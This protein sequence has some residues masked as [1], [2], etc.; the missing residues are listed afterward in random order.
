M[1][2][3]YWL[4]ALACALALIFKAPL[5]H[6]AAMI[7]A[8]LLFIGGG[9]PHGAFDIAVLRRAIDLDRR[10][11]WRV[12]ASYVAVAVLMALL[13]FSVP[14]VALILFLAVAAVHFGEDWTML[15]EPL[16]RFAAGAAIIA[17]PT[18]GH[19]ND[20]AALFVAM[21]DARALILAR[22]ITAAAPVTLLV[23][24]VSIG[25]AWLDGSRQ[26]A[27]AMALCLVL[28]LLLPPVLGFAL[29]F[30]FLH[31]P[32]HLIA[33]RTMLDDIS[34][35]RWL[36]IGA[37]FSVA[38]VLGWCALQ[39]LAPT[40]FATD[41]TAQAFQFLAAVAVPHLLLSRWVD[42]RLALG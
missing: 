25:V 9:L 8:T 32:P 15:D 39:L 12:I 23:A 5:G 16:L 36:G 26:W 28:L 1:H 41:A 34:V 38:A 21:S 37:A 10:G 17:A 22:I 31:A 29:F 11:L 19:F 3:T 4:A 24:C 42:R 27:V 40:P 30:V 6:S 2:A 13:W 33:S 35:G 18:I 7:G 14:L 20:V